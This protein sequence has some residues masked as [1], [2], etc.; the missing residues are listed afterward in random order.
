[1]A[2]LI[3]D[4]P[5]ECERLLRIILV[6]F[7]NHKYYNDWQRENAYNE[8]YSVKY[9]RSIQWEINFD[10]EVPGIQYGN[11]VYSL[12]IGTMAII[13][14]ADEAE[15]IFSSVI[16]SQIDKNKFPKTFLSPMMCISSLERYAVLLLL[17]M[18]C[19]RNVVVPIDKAI[20]LLH[21]KKSRAIAM[22][23]QSAK[24]L[25]INQESIQ[26][27]THI[28]LNIWDYLL[29]TLETLT[30][31]RFAQWLEL[32]YYKTQTYINDLHSFSTRLMTLLLCIMSNYEHY[33]KIRKT[34]DKISK[35]FIKKKLINWIPGRDS[36][37]SNQML[38][39]IGSYSGENLVKKVLKSLQQFY[40]NTSKYGLCNIHW[41]HNAKLPS[42]HSKMEITRKVIEVELDN[43]KI[44]L[45]DPDEAKMRDADPV[46]ESEVQVNDQ[47]EEMCD[48][49]GDF[50][51]SS[52]HVPTTVLVWSDSTIDC[53]KRIFSYCRALI[54]NKTLLNTVVRDTEITLYRLGYD[55]NKVFM[56]ID[57]ICPLLVLVRRLLSTIDTDIL[58]VT[59]SSVSNKNTNKNTANDSNIEDAARTAKVMLLDIMPTLQP[60]YETVAHHLNQ[61]KNYQCTKEDSIAYFQIFTNEIMERIKNDVYLQNIINLL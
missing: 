22:Q 53:M 12:G 3:N 18:K 29:D 14:G 19:Y 51:S 49:S 4:I 9:I 17:Q 13:E 46:I 40:L 32:S 20:F 34:C 54:K 42:Y 2:E 47:S 23:I 15:R 58:R 10:E 16:P 26:Q 60:D 31:S 57:Y 45:L 7:R 48:I 24:A 30:H 56:Y 28:L 8:Y 21:G 43:N 44:L 41:N 6:E 59:A 50:M 1:M 27:A 52:V 11:Y 33:G 37:F 35:N 39:L 38:S 61:Y 25:S 55:L 5:K 36:I